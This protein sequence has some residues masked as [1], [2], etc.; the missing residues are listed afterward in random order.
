MPG[1]FDSVG[2][3]FSNPFGLFGSDEPSTSESQISFNSNKNTQTQDSSFFSSAGDFISEAGDIVIE[4][5][6]KIIKNVKPKLNPFSLGID[7]GNAV[8]LGPN[9]PVIRETGDFFASTTQSVIGVENT[10]NLFNAISSGAGVVN[11]ALDTIDP[12]QLFTGTLNLLTPDFSRPPGG[13][14]GNDFALQVTPDGSN[15][16]LSGS[17]DTNTLG[18]NFFS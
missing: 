3:F 12:L 18:G 7:I 4:K 8:D 17:S 15:Q 2:S 1:F 10:A 14:G 16:S 5:G 9:A 13:F 11:D 6:E